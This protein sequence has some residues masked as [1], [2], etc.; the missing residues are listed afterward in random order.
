MFIYQNQDG[1]YFVIGHEKTPVSNAFIKKN[2]IN[3]RIKMA[4][5]PFNYEHSGEYITAEHRKY[6]RVMLTLRLE[7]VDA[8]KLYNAK[9]SDIRSYL[10]G[11][12]PAF[13]SG[14]VLNYNIEEIIELQRKL[15]D[16]E[17]FPGLLNDLR[18][19]GLR[20][21]SYTSLV[22]K[23]ALQNELDQ[24]HRKTE[25]DIGKEI[26]YKKAHKKTEHDLNTMDAV[27]KAKSIIAILQAYDRLLIEESLSPDILLET[28][29]LEHKDLL[30]SHWT[31]KGILLEKPEEKGKLDSMMEEMLQGIDTK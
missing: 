7:I 26:M 4:S 30:R 19:I 3:Y 13:I 6:F 12:I 22:K 25:H 1:E 24:D 11:V 8:V 21:A 14:V 28:V 23:D 16:V 10:D 15:K 17:V 18:A 29:E 27:E 9:V 2:N 5:G 20:V 31:K